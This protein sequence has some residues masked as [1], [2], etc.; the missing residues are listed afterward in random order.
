MDVYMGI[1]INILLIFQLI[2]KNF[3]LI[4]HENLD[5]LIFLENWYDRNRVWQMNRNP[6]G[7]K[8]LHGRI[9]ALD[10]DFEKQANWVEN[11]LVFD[12]ESVAQDG[13]LRQRHNPIC[14]HKHLNL[15]LSPNKIQ[16]LNNMS[17]IPVL[18]WL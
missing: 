18:N 16:G 13:F 12:L 17:P 9:T 5:L 14:F 7:L 6:I 15:H 11:R 2:F 4:L 1:E 8:P 3:V 10:L